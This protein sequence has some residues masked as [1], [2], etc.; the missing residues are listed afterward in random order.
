MYRIAIAAVAAIAL[1]TSAL[2][3]DAAKPTDPQIVHIAYTASV[4]DIDA[5][6]QALDKSK[7]K[8]VRDFAQR[9]IG[10][11]TAVNDQALTLVKKLNVTPEDNPTSKDL[12]KAAEATHQKLAALSG[13]AFDKAYVDNEVA[14]HRTV[15]DALSQT[16][17]PNA[18][19]A[20]LKAL[21]EQGL[22]LFQA[23]QQHAEKLAKELQKG[24]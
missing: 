22:K 2:A 5:A 1:A 18:Q 15:N 20:E 3:A 23:H 24:S 7:N 16:L 6:K 17:I 10:D 9:M 8:D 14:Y 19:N 13:E 11:H 21:L 12:T 4:L